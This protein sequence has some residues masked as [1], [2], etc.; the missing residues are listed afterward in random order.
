MGKLRWD[1]KVGPS[2]ELGD[3][4]GDGGAPVDTVLHDVSNATQ[5]VKQTLHPS[6]PRERGWSW[7]P[8]QFADEAPL[9][10]LLV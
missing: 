9:T 5:N 4:K 10:P 2:V 7:S 1:M 3:G 8:Y 6:Y